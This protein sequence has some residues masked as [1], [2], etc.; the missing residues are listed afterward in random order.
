[1]VLEPHLTLFQKLEEPERGIRVQLQPTTLIGL[2]FQPL[3]FLFSQP[4][5]MLS[6]LLI[7][8]S[9]FSFG[10][11]TPSFVAP[12]LLFLYGN[13]PSLLPPPLVFFYGNTPSLLPLLI[14]FLCSHTPSLLQNLAFLSLFS[15][16]LAFDLGLLLSHFALFSCFLSF[17]QAFCLSLSSSLVFLINYPWSIENALAK[18]SVLSPGSSFFVGGVD[19]G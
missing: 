15:T 11:D 1:M 3:I 9:P 6:S 16:C 10:M 14:L 17:V 2:S 8:V 12:P 5:L 4:S 13:T 19:K 7:L 18:C